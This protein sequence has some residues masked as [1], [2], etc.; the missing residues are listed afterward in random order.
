MAAL[1]SML[2]SR[3]SKWMG[4]AYYRN[5]LL[6]KT[7]LPDIIPKIPGSGFVFQQDG[8][9]AHRACDT[10]AFLVSFLQHCGLR[11]HRIWTQKT[12]ASGV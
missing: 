12:I 10:V 2:S 3:V 6:A 1:K 4:H 11:I 9:L 5:N 7:L 8:A